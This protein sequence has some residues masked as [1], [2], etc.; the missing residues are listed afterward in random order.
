M[1]SAGLA[2]TLVTAEELR[3]DPHL[4]QVA[5]GVCT[6]ISQGDSPDSLPSELI[7]AVKWRK[8]QDVEDAP[9]SFRRQVPCPPS[10]LNSFRHKRSYGQGT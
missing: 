1:G 9:T 4:Q 10:R 7:K 8:G 5:R 2:V 6:L 3:R